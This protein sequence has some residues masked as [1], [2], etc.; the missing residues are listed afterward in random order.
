MSQVHTDDQQVPLDTPEDVSALDFDSGFTDGEETSGV[1]TDA[2]AVQAAQDAA[3]HTSP[4]TDTPVPAATSAHEQAAPQEPVPAAPPAPV[5]YETQPQPEP[6]K[7]LDMP[8][9]IRA[10]Y[11]ELKSLNPDAAALAEEDSPEGQA[12]RKRLEQYGADSAMDRADIIMGQ[13]RN[14]AA[15]R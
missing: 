5:S 10:E 2:Q 4:A 6:V 14:E 7:R 8:D 13:R 3:Q 12:I 15:Q 11:E 1:H 9:E